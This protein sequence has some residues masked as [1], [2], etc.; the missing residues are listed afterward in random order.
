MS[1]RETE[2]EDAVARFGRVMEADG[3]FRDDTMGWAR[4]DATT[5]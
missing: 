1:R 3:M 2:G 5:I 4:A